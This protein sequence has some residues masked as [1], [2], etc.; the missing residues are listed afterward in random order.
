MRQP[1][2]FVGGGCDCKQHFKFTACGTT[3]S[4]CFNEHFGK[5]SRKFSMISFSSFYNLKLFIFIKKKFIQ[6]AYFPEIVKDKQQMC[7]DEGEMPIHASDLLHCDQSVL[8]FVT[9]YS[10]LFWISFL[11]LL[12]N[13]NDF[14]FILILRT[15]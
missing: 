15:F 4:K 7:S 3:F 1:L 8:R 11:L 2:A 10:G 6:I 14:N 9:F 12:D 13:Q 5:F